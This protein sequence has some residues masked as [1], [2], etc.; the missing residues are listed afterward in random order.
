MPNTSNDAGKVQSGDRLR[1]PA[2]VYNGLIDLIRKDKDTLDSNSLKNSLRSNLIVDVLNDTGEFLPSLSV[3]GLFQ[4]VGNADNEPLSF[5]RRPVFVADT[6]TLDC[7][8]AILQV[9]LD[10]GEIGKAVVN[11]ITLARVLVNDETQNWVSH[12][13]GIVDYMETVDCGE[14]RIIQY[15]IGSGGSADTTGSLADTD[16]GDSIA[17]ELALIQLIGKCDEVTN[18]CSK[19]ALIDDDDCVKFIVLDNPAPSGRCSDTETGQVSFGSGVDGV[20]T[21]EDTFTFNGSQWTVSYNKKSCTSEPGL[22]LNKVVS[23]SDTPVSIC[24]YKTK[25]GI[26]NGHPYIDFVISDEAVCGG[27]RGPRCD[28]GSFTIRV[29]CVDPPWWCIESPD[30]NGC[31]QQC[32]RPTGDGVIVFS[33]PHDTESECDDECCIVIPNPVYDG[34]GWYC[35]CDGTTELYESDPMSCICLR[36]GPYETE[37]EAIAA[38]E[39]TAKMNCCVDGESAPVALPARLFARFFGGS[40]RAAIYNGLVVPL[41]N[42]TPTVDNSPWTGTAK[43]PGSGIYSYNTTNILTSVSTSC[44]YSDPMTGG[45]GKYHFGLNVFYAYDFAPEC[46]FGGAHGTNVMQPVVDSVDSSICSRPYSRTY[47]PFNL[48][49]LDPPGNC[50]LAALESTGTLMV[51]ITD[52]I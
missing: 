41:D 24:G 6:P 20:W 35:K 23:M 29:I 7:P 25:C 28:R 17:T 11:G 30:L 50:S 9:P 10:I 19:I 14:A 12:I 8:I 48:Q 51:E 38:C 27:T 34:A 5:I 4:P 46:G 44:T 47:G 33:G 31:V 2:T 32:N 22:T 45:D 3:I 36:S 18:D 15:L 21:G 1:I 16:S 52:T 39:V 13:D 49:T 40:G 37:E 42:T 26:I 43:V